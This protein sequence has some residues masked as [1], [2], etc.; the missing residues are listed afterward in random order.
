M[1]QAERKILNIIQSDFPLESRPYAVIAEKLDLTEAEVLAKIRSLT[2]KG[3]I[4][5]IGA[6]FNSSELGFASTLCA[7]KVPDDKLEGFVNYLNALPG[8]THNYLRANAYN[9]WF[10]YI[11]RDE[12]EINC[13]LTE[14]KS[15]SGI[16]ALKLPAKHM[17]KIQ[18]DFDLLHGDK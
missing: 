11:G 6:I 3:V 4:R 16:E 13:M 9:V 15:I 10:T 5:R 1:N 8:V 14:L 7:A 17:Y 12:A 18:V 2:S